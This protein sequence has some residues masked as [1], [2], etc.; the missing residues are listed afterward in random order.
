MASHSTAATRKRVIVFAPCEFVG[1]PASPLVGE[2][3]GRSRKDS[4]AQGNIREGPRALNLYARAGAG[5]AG[6]QAGAE[7][8]YAPRYLVSL[9]DAHLGIRGAHLGRGEQPLDPDLHRDQL[10]PA[11]FLNR[12]HEVADADL[13]E[14]DGIAIDAE[15]RG[16]PLVDLDE[17]GGVF[18]LEDEATLSTIIL[19]DNAAPAGR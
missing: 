1:T 18:R 10:R 15:E 11:L 17:T 2:N 4:S 8:C 16:R 6:A 19:Q 5:G 13:G 9:R 7:K 14:R 3:R 12:V